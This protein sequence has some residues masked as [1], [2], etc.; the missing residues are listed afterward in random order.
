MSVMG[1]VPCIHCQADDHCGLEHE[2]M[3]GKPEPS[4]VG[5][6]GRVGVDGAVKT[7]ESA[8][9]YG[10]Y[11]TYAV[12]ASSAPFR[13]LSH[14]AHRM[15][16]VIMVDGTNNSVWIGKREQIFSSGSQGILVSSGQ[17]VTIKNVQ[18]VWVAN[19]AV[20]CN[21]SVINERWES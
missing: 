5:I 20:D 21:V 2:E 10:A 18:E 9:D 15:R 12:G 19:N 11:S 8:A 4:L 17:P 16:A 7:N 6:K 3:F 13:I 1:I 14:D